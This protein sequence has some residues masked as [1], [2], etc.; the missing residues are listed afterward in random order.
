MFSNISTLYDIPGQAHIQVTS[1]ASSCFLFSDSDIKEAIWVMNNY[2]ATYEEGFQEEFFKHGLRDFVSY[3]ADLFNHVLR[4]DFP[5]AWSHH[6]IHLI[7]K[8]GP[9][10]LR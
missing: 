8:S 5:P 4:T 2:K 3:L 10:W 9:E 1:S 6:I 7:H